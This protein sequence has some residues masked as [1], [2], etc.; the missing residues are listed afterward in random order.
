MLADAMIGLALSSVLLVM[1]GSLW[2]YG[3]QSLAATREYTE[4][5][6]RGGY[7][8]RLKSPD[9]RQ[10]TQAVA[11]QNSRDTKCLVV[12]NAVRGKTTTCAWKACPQP[13]IDQKTGQHN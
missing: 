7:V 8:L 1:T 4:R 3:I 6:A 5:T 9:L 12:T 13:L 10:A 2:A 11:F